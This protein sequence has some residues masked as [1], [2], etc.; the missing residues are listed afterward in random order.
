VVSDAL[1]QAF[2]AAITPGTVNYNAR[3]ARAAFMCSPSN[4]TPAFSWSSW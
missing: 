2:I 3:P 4:K 1:V